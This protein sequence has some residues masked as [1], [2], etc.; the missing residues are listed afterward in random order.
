MNPPSDG[1]AM[2]IS[3]GIVLVFLIG[4]A[5]GCLTERDEQRKKDKGC[6]NCA[7][8]VDAQASAIR[9]AGRVTGAARFAA[10]HLQDFDD[11]DAWE[12]SH[13]R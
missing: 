9:A 6:P 2:L 7:K 8:I 3:L 10:D 5:V 13:A 4:L 1:L 12:D 11:D